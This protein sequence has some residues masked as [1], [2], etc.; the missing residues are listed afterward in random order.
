M[1]QPALTPRQRAWLEIARELAGT[2]AVRIVSPRPD[3]PSR[4][5]PDG[6][7]D[8]SPTTAGR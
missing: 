8:S 2:E 3:K 5:N 1:T 4:G 7:R 6:N